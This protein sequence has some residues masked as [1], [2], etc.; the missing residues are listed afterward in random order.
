MFPL[1]K[2]RF[3][4][5]IKGG[6]SLSLLVI[7]NI[8]NA[9]QTETTL[10]FSS[11]NLPIV[12]IETHGQTIPYDDPRIVADM[13][14]IFNGSGQRNNV[15][16]PANNYSGKISIEIRGQSSAGWDKK[17]YALETQN[18]DG[19]NRNVS[20]LGLPEENDWILYAPYYDRSLL[21]NTLT[22]HLAREMGWYASRTVY[23]ELVLDSA[24][25]GIYV[26]MDKI[27]RDK[28]RVDIAKLKPDEISGDDLTGGYIL[29][30]D[31]EPWND[32]FDSQFPPYE[33]S[34]DA[35][36]YQYYYPKARE[37]V[38]EQEAYIKGFIYGFENLMNSGDFSNPV[39]GYARYL[40]VASFIDY[41]ILN[42]LSRNVD[43]YRL[44]AFLYKEKESNGGKLY[45][46]PVWDYNFSYGN[47]GYY[48]S[49]L[50]EGWQLRY[51]SDNAE[52]H[53]YDGFQ[54]PFWW[55]LLFTDKSFTTQL[56]ERWQALRQN[57][58]DL[59]NIYAFIDQVAD[60]TA[61]ARVRNFEIWPGPGA[62]ELGG[63]WFPDDPRSSQIN[64][65]EDELI[66]TEDWI[67]DRILWLDTNIPLLT[68][69]TDNAPSGLP[70]SFNLM[71][72][73]P[74]PFN[75][76]T[77]IRYQVAR[78]CRVTLTIYNALGKKVKELINSEQN[79]GIYSI[80]I[81]ASSL[82]SGVYYYKLSA[83]SFVQ[84]RKMILMK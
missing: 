38:P 11:S 35:V 54:M 63:G 10:G 15:T 13:S 59:A 45:A 68:S 18:E 30:V 61:E 77:K 48:D 65:Y 23:C 19:S 2:I 31:K 9:Q 76:E 39:S 36:R 20:I 51:F 58:L 70:A 46:G 24:Y 28:N 80:S 84:V 5:K 83:G 22:F 25:Q 44:S 4:K 42:E 72:N 73:Y 3:L 8:L 55:K 37:I 41:V 81:D 32:G 62:T 34:T 75:P 26:F 12:I 50:I 67:R 64:S 27:K 7:A 49:W 43:G 79:A 21:R 6:L 82:A 74:N 71:Q 33:G 29:R 56:A 1:I 16:D 69:I 66:L 53:L 17:S 60:T 78:Q 57:I 14:V 40:N 52:F 47:V